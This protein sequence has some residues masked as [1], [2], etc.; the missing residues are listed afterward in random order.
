MQSIHD[1]RRV[2]EKVPS[3][4]PRCQAQHD[5]YRIS[6]GKDQLTFQ[7]EKKEQRNYI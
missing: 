4:D 5:F 3:H 7:A 6:S 2:I 1:I